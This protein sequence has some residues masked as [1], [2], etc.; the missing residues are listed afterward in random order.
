MTT[1]YYS[2]QE[3]FLHNTGSDHPEHALRLLAIE[4]EL[5]K[6][7]L[8]DQLVH[9]NGQPANM[10]DILRTHSPKYVEE[11]QL[12]QPAQGHIYL[13]E[14]TPMSTGTLEAA[15]YSRSEEHT[16]ELQSRPHLVC[17]L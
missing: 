17:R 12:I 5:K 11:L 1:A 4:Q 2:Y 16:S 3:H 7:N 9:V 15:L 6:R 10:P 8:W 14:D 13:D